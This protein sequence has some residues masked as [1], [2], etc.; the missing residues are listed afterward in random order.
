MR[1][2]SK[3][4]YILQLRGTSWH[5]SQ[6]TQLFAILIAEICTVCG[7][8]INHDRLLRRN[9]RGMGRSLL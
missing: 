5:P 7:K 2:L 6:S 9:V 3:S 1:T 4:F 8:E